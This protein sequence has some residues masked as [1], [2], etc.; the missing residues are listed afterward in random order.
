MY[1]A[2]V[3]IKV[4]PQI[5][6]SGK[7]NKLIPCFIKISFFCADCFPDDTCIASGPSIQTSSHQNTQRINMVMTISYF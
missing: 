7:S 4:V 3:Q 1:L 5:F 2:E 6:D